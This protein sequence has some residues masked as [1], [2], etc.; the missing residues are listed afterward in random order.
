M[1]VDQARLTHLQENRHY[2]EYGGNENSHHENRTD[3]TAG[4]ETQTRTGI[5]RHSAE[6]RNDGDGNAS[7]IERADKVLSDTGKIPGADIIVELQCGRQGPR[8]L[9]ELWRCFK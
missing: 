7:D 6:N 1:P 5:G 3:N 2:T 9:K 4:F 8:V